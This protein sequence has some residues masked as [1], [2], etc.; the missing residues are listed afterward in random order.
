MRLIKLTEVMNQ[1][2]LG[3]SSVYK[4]MKEG[5]FPKP[6]TQ[7]GRSKAWVESEVQEWILDK[8]EQRDNDEELQIVG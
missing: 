5:L 2:A 1:T 4:Y 3:H 8:I 7:I 6:V